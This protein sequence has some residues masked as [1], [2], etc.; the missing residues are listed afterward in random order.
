MPETTTPDTS[1]NAFRILDR[2]EWN[3]I[4]KIRDFCFDQ[5]SW[6]LE[7]IK[8]LTRTRAEELVKAGLL[9]YNDWRDGRHYWLT[10]KAL[11]SYILSIPK[12]QAPAL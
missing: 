12:Y 2:K 9:G 8:G 1:H 5:T 11:A 7:Q 3:A 6:K 10:E 4:Q